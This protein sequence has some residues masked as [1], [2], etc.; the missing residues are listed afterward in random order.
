LRE[1]LAN[2]PDTAFAAVLH[3]L[4]LSAFYRYSSGSCLEISAKSA[5]FSTQAPSLADSASAKAIEARYQ[6]WASQLPKGEDGLWDALVAF[7]GD[8]Q[9]A[10]F[11]HCASL[12]VNAVHEPWNRNPRRLAHAD[13]LA[14]TVKL[15]MAAAGWSPRVDN[16]L[17]RVPKARILE[18]VREAK[19]EASAQLVDHLKKP[20]MA[21]E[22]ERLLA[23]T[24]WVPEPLRTPDAS[25][26]EVESESSTEALPAFLAD[27]EDDKAGDAT[28]SDPEE[29]HAVAAE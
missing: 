10:L 6:H 1:A 18:A 5:G 28:A 11:A 8:S 13:T 29:P 21:R 12:S 2:D 4:C 24:G 22:A 14:R 9:A 3:A 27:G 20:D 7:D 23:G 25:S 19:G 26:G 17:G 15:D 16:Y